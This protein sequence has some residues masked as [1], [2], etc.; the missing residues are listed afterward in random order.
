M[1]LLFIIAHKYCRGYETYLEYYINNIQS[2]YGNDANVLIVDNN[3]ICLEDIHEKISKYKNVEIIINTSDSKFELG[4]YRFG[5]NYINEKINE[6]EY[7]IFIQD[8]FV[9]KNKY[10]FNNL[11]INDVKACTIVS[12]NE[13]INDE[14]PFTFCNEE[15]KN[16]LEQINLYNKLNEITFCWCVSFILHNSV[17]NDFIKLTN[18]VIIKTKKDSQICERFLA[19]ILYELNNHKNFDIDG[20]Y[21]D[22]KYNVYFTNIYN[23]LDGYYFQKINQCKNENTL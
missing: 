4:A 12:H 9:L 19:R 7:I 14:S 5:I 17:I 15:N 3:S 16:I 1:K 11:T 21:Y 6:Y 2:F 20:Y 18:H 23:N 22:L 13:Y 8:T 10:D